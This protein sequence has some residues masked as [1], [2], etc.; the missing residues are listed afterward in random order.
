[1]RISVSIVASIVL[2]TGSISC[3]RCYQCAVRNKKAGDSI[4]YYYKEVCA[5]KKDY[6]AYKQIC[7]EALADTSEVTQ[8]PPSDSLY[9]NCEHNL[10]LE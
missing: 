3:K 1:M 7:E 6:K 4:E 9:C 2:I 5:T 10:V 8:R